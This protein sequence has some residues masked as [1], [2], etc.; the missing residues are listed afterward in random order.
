M[1]KLLCI[2]C[3][4][5]HVFINAVEAALLCL[6]VV[7]IPVLLGL[8]FGTEF[9]GLSYA[10]CGIIIGVVICLFCFGGLILSGSEYYE[11]HYKKGE[12]D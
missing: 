11:K 1:I 8:Y 12:K 7:L 2:I 4:Y 3:H 10:E 6:S 9:L 5:I